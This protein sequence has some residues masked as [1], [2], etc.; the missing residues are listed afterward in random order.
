ML[1]RSFFLLSGEN[2]ELSAAELRQVLSIV[3]DLDVFELIN[4]RIASANV[5]QHLH[6]EIV[7]RAALTKM[8]G[9]IIGLG[10]VDNLKKEG[11]NLAAGWENLVP[12]DA[13]GFGVEVVKIGGAIVNSLEMER[14]FAEYVVSSLPNLRVSLERPDIVFV[15]LVSP[16]TYVAGIAKASKPKHFFQSRRA[17]RKP[18][19]IPSALQPK[20]ARCLV[21]LAVSSRDSRVLDPF[22]GSGAILIEAGLMGHEA[23]G[24]ELKTWI[25]NGMALNIKPY[26]PSVCHIVQGDAKRPPFIA[27][28]DAVATDPPYGRS[29]TLAGHILKTLLKKFFEAVSGALH[30]KARIA[31]IVPKEEYENLLEA[32][33]GFIPLQHHDVYVHKSLTRRIVVLRLE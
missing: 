20:L 3:N 32:A 30:D 25:S 22:A 11:V 4:P 17:G 7:E 14:S 27:G 26:C 10:S 15:L 19:R 21:N 23:V 29:A 2:P 13:L 31:I 8:A 1:G 28:F 9:L 18:F 6:G 16:T 24:L 12:N 33:V 5:P